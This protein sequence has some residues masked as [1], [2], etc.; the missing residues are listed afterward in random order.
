MNPAEVSVS[1][2]MSA[3]LCPP[4]VLLSSPLEAP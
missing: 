2:A 4:V 1:S 3:I